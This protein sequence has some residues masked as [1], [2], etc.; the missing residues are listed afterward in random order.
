MNDRPSPLLDAQELLHLALRD[1]ESARHDAAIAKLKEACAL[2]ADDASIQFLLAAEYAEIGL[3]D[4]AVEGMKRAL[5][6]NPGLEI[7]RFQLGLVHY[8]KGQI[9]D[10]AEAWE[11]LDQLDDKH[12]L[13][14]FKSALLNIAGADYGS[15]I[16][17]LEKAL[18]AEPAI[19]ALRS[20]ISRLLDNAREQQKSTASSDDVSPGHALLHRYGN[21]GD[22]DR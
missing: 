10:A 22:G 6:I 4:R 13:R 19:P 5:Q 8:A 20:D 12:S 3:H 18:T 7:A 11:P 9:S 2:D 1:I 16:P 17:L 21:T 14:L 15:A